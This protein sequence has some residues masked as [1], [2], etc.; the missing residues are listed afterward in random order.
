MNA[1]RP[2]FSAADL[3]GFARCKALT[4]SRLF[5][6]AALALTPAAGRAQQPYASPPYG[7]SDPYAG[8]YAQPA[9]QYGYAQQPYPQPQNPQ[10]QAQPPQYSGEQTVPGQPQYADQQPYAPY[11]SEE[12]LA[13]PPAAPVQALSAE[14][15]E[16]MLAPIALYPDALLAQILAASTY[17]AEVSAADQWLQ[18][19]R[20]QGYGSPEQIASGANTQTTWDPSIKALTAFPDVL[21][22]LSRNLQWTTALGN[23]YYNQPQD[24]MQTVQVLRQRAEQAGNLQSKPQENVTNTQGYIDIA[25]PNPEQVYV[26]TYDPWDVYGQPISPYPGFSLIGALGNFFGSTLGSGLGSGPIQ[27]A[28]SFALGA[29]EHTPFGWLAWGLDWLGQ[30]ILFDHGAWFSHSATV[31][32]WGLP[33]GGPRAYPGWWHGPVPARGNFNHGYGGSYASNQRGAWGGNEGRSGNFERREPGVAYG[34][35]GDQ[36][37]RGGEQFNRGNQ[38]YGYNRGAYQMNGGYQRPYNGYTRPDNAANARGADPGQQAYYHANPQPGATYRPQQ[39]YANPSYGYHPQ[40]YPNRA[41]TYAGR[42]QTPS[43]GGSGYGYG[44]ANRS[45]QSYASRPGYGYGNSNSTYR[46]PRF[47]SRSYPS[48]SNPPRGDFFARNESRGFHGFSGDKAP[49]Y[50]APKYSYKAPK[51]FGHESFGHQSFGHQSF[52]HSGSGHSGFGHSG[53]HSGGGGHKHFL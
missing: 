15:L 34:A 53:G 45:T 47:D 29:F 41:Q 1:H 24:V 3:N 39:S 9:P 2:S 31:A 19:M 21:D 33:H 48:R 22:M 5:L 43:F 11:P 20:S 16:Q 50:S 49:K 10:P 28:L 35:R 23:A 27:Y 40:T 7:N 52:G 36:W 4:V 42:P 51:N 18:Q 6:L 44:Y 12:D 26:P 38:S 14:Q 8:R 13:P 37:G 46:A 32:D 30:A 17:P 25:P